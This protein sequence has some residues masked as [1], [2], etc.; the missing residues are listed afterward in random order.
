LFFGD[1]DE[2]AGSDWAVVAVIVD[3]FKVR[4]H[5]MSSSMA[6]SWFVTAQLTG[7]ICSCLLIIFG[8]QVFILG[9][10]DVSRLKFRENVVQNLFHQPFTI[11]GKV[12]EEI[13]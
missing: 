5:Q 9:V 10:C 4:S 11:F 6:V 3:V 7:Q 2:A 8:Q 1:A 13:L 12:F